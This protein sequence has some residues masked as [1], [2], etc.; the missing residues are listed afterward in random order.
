MADVVIEDES[1]TF[2]KE[3][4]AAKISPGQEL[5]KDERYP[6]APPAEKASKTVLLL[7]ARATMLQEVVVILAIIPVWL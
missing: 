3:L 5:S 2:E 6:K 4:H 7:K 1:I